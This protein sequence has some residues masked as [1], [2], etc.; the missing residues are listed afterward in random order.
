MT[1]TLARMDARITR[2]RVCDG[3]VIP[4]M[5]AAPVCD[6]CAARALVELARR[7]S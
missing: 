3:Y 7:A 4:A 1:T 2:C 5:G 6:T